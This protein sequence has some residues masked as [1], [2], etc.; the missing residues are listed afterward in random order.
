MKAEDLIPG[1]IYYFKTTYEWL[2]RFKRIDEEWIRGYGHIC[3][4]SYAKGYI[5]DIKW[6]NIIRPAIPKEIKQYES[7]EYPKWQETVFEEEN[8]F[9]IF[10]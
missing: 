9:L 4:N 5:N 2:V 3:N 1:Q 7:L 10:N 8:K 6:H